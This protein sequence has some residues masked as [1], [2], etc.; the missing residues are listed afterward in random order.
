MLGG[1]HR[2]GLTAHL[3]GNYIIQNSTPQKSNIDLYEFESE[4]GLTTVLAVNFILPK[5]RSLETSFTQLCITQ[6]CMQFSQ[7]VQNRKLE[8]FTATIKSQMFSILYST[9]DKTIEEMNKK[10]LIH[11]EY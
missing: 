2:C 10:R 11:Y 6:L 9:T 1:L 3:L 8:S 5:K 7:T 4:C